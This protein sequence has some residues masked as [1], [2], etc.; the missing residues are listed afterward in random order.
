M[1]AHVVVAIV[2]ALSSAETDANGIDAFNARVT[3]YLRIR[4]EIT[5]RLPAPE[6][7]F[8]DPAEMLRQRALLREAI[9]NARAGARRGDVFTPDAALAFRRII[10]STVV[11][12]RVDPRYL[13]HGFNDDRLPGA[14]RPAVNGK[15][16]WRLGAWMWPAL[17]RDLP[18]LP[19]E[20]EYRIVDDDLVLIDPRASL[21]VDILDDA[22]DFD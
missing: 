9:R 16:D 7:M 10:V 13:V 11:T 15:F 12:A 21:V 1:L 18:R 3:D 6:R 14:K 17:L 2:V 4:Q 22:L 8:D 19:P 5:A 20:L